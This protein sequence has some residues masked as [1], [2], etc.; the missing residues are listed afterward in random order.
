L[1]QRKGHKDAAALLKA[2]LLAGHLQGT[3]SAARRP[4]V[5]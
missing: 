5:V 4:R 3:P 2:I 1:L